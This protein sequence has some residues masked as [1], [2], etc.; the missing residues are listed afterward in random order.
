MYKKLLENKVF[1]DSKFLPLYCL[2]ITTRIKSF[3]SKTILKA[4]E[5]MTRKEHHRRSFRE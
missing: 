1:L 4:L 5:N 2:L 3:K